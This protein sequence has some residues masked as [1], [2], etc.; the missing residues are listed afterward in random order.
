[1]VNGIS[2]E[3]YVK[4]V[5]IKDEFELD[6][7]VMNLERKARAGRMAGGVIEMK[8]CAL[9]YRQPVLARQDSWHSSL[10]MRRTVS[11]LDKHRVLDPRN[12]FHTCVTGP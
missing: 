4:V 5:V 7:N 11:R 2:P 9:R 10:L 8:L 1:M 6:S 3:P 12:P